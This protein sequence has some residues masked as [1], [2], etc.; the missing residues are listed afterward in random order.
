MLP[1]KTFVLA[2]KFA[3]CIPPRSS[4]SSHRVTARTIDFSHNSLHMKFAHTKLTSFAWFLKHAE[5]HENRYQYWPTPIYGKQG[6]CVCVWVSDPVRVFVHVKNE[7]FSSYMHLTWN[8]DLYSIRLWLHLL[9]R[10]GWLH[11]AR[12]LVCLRARY[13]VVFIIKK[14]FFFCL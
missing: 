9:A 6:V 13:C 10:F 4:S 8:K 11:G 3:C 5:K 2:P 12:W 14:I 7:P 1:L